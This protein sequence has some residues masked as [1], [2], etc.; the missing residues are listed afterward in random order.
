[1]EGVDG[2]FI[3]PYDLSIGLGIGGQFENP[4]FIASMERIK[5]ACHSAGKFVIIFTMS[6]DM[7][8]KYYAQGFDSVTLG[9]DI[10]YYIDACARAAEEAKN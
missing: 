1:M 4:E 5:I 6:I 7:A 3:E 8:K 10:N 2:I 9:L